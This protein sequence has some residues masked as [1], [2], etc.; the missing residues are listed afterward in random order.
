M[1]QECS[2]SQRIISEAVEMYRD[3]YPEPP[4]PEP[5][6]EVFDAYIYFIRCG[7]HVKIGI[8]NNIKRRLCIL[9]IGNPVDLILLG[10]VGTNQPD[11]DEYALHVAL[12]KYRTR[13]EWFA[14]PD[15]VLAPLVSGDWSTVPRIR[16]TKPKQDL[17]ES[18]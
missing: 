3:R 5:P 18:S 16:K 2:I 15:D 10:A 14:L 12:H 1:T 17:I 11:D 13:G 8:A 7:N 6:P 4:P 9:Q